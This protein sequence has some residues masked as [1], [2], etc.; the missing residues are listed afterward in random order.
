MTDAPQLSGLSPNGAM[1][2]IVHDLT[3]ADGQKVTT[4][5]VEGAWF[6]WKKRETVVPERDLAEILTS[7]EHAEALKKLKPF[8]KTGS[9]KDI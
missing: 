3:K 7:C 9:A 4:I 5:T 6:N 1:W 2:K 8:S